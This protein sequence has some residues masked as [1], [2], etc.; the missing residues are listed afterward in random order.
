MNRLKRGKTPFEAFGH[1]PDWPD[2]AGRAERLPPSKRWRFKPDA[3]DIFDGRALQHLDKKTREEYGLAGGFL[4]RQLNETKYLS[5]L[6]KI[7]L[8][9][10]CDPDQIY[11]T[12]G[13]LTG[14]LRGKWGLNSLLSDDNR[15]NRTDHRHHGLDAVVIGAM[16]RGLVSSLA[17]DSARAEH[18]EFD[19]VVGKV[20][21]PFEGFHDAVRSKLGAAIV[22]NKP[23]HGKK[24]ALHEDT[25]YG[26]IAN[27]EEAERIGNLV[28]RKP[29]ADLTGGEIDA[30]RDKTLREKLQALA[31]P[32]RDGKGKIKD[33]KALAAALAGFAKETSIRRVRVGK[34][35]DSV[36]R[37]A[38]RR[39]GH[40]Y[41]AVTPGENHHIDVVQMRDGSWRGF[42][43]TVFD[44][45]RKEWRPQWEREKLGGKLVMRLH[46]G[47]AVEVDDKDGIRRVKTVVRI[48]PSNSVLYLVPHNE[49]GDYPK[50]HA[51]PDD[52]FR[53]D[54]A[55]VPGL[56]DRNCVAARVD[57]IGQI[58]YRKRN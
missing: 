8:G 16:T 15:K 26:L 20:P 10:I 9:K 45:N 28:R 5:R 49:G 13:T 37:I 3:M 21:L 38:D 24:G 54:F 29:L 36:V 51:D 53:W 12:P 1:T 19:A 35:D 18:G 33:E 31:A 30:I 58:S 6:A 48:S 42:A 43:A 40:I 23:E 50:R 25:A 39:T 4:A 32:F 44:V 17:R 41:K 11:V 22:S 2:I 55:N 46:K 47:D 34:S 52:P 27:Q 14:L 57:E 7:Y 56:R